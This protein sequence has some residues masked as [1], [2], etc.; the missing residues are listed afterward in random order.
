MTKSDLVQKV[1]A[2][3][4]DEE[5][6][7]AIIATIPGENTAEVSS[8]VMDSVADAFQACI[9][10]KQTAIDALYDEAGV[11]LDENDPEY[12]AA[13]EA[14]MAEIDA[15]ETD[16]ETEMTDIEN[17]TKKV[18]EEAETTQAARLAGDIQGVQE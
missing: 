15:A 13:H 12:K 1:T 16:F 18:V 3:D 9:D 11:T 8:E 17:E 7:A 2:Y 5:S 14:M 10:K 4:I 6:K